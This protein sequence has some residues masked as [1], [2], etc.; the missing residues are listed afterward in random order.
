MEFNIFDRLHSDIQDYDRNFLMLARTSNTNNKTGGYRYSQR[1]TVNLIELYCSSKFETGAIDS[2]GQRKFFLNIVRFRQEVAEKQ[3]DIDVK[4]FLFVPEDGTPEINAT[5]TAK[6]FRKWSREKRF[7]KVLNELNHD[8]SKY[9]TCVAKIIGD[10]IERVPLLTFRVQQDAHSIECARYAI[11]EHENMSA[12]A[13]AEYEDW[14]VEKL[15]LKF[16]ETTNVFEWYGYV[17][18]DW[19]NEQNGTQRS[20]KTGS[21]YVQAILAPDKSA[22]NSSNKGGTILF[23]EETECL[24]REAHYSRIDG[25][26]LGVGEVEKNFENQIFRNVVS[27]MRR[28]GLIWASKKLFQSSDPD[29]GQNLIRDVKDGDVLKVAPNGEIKQINM[30]TQTVGEFDDAAKEI[31]QN[32]DQTSFTFEVA[33]GEGLPSGTPFRLGVILSKAVDSYYA[34][35]RENFGLFLEDMFYDLII[36]VFK[37]ESR[38]EHLLFFKNDEN[39]IQAIRSRIIDFYVYRNAMDEILKGKHINLDQIRS[40]VQEKINRNDGE[41]L[42]IPEGFYDMVKATVI[43]VT[44]GENMDVGKRIESLT[45][46]YQALVKSG[47]P[48]AEKVLSKIATLAGEDPS[49]FLASKADI[50][51][52]ASQIPAIPSVGGQGI[53]GGP[54]AAVPQNAPE[55]VAQPA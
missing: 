34:L 43:L 11:I 8:Y 2:E 49:D 14:D 26:W 45:N 33:T 13:M 38:K 32:A 16:G 31:D 22:K 6:A 29:I 20:S 25:R 4:D 10:C 19:F 12:E 21:I 1:D 36:P 52:P 35:K 53:P 44:T 40:Q 23:L 37:K 15:G 7:G 51:A 24:F 46:F 48:R 50:P 5:I 47:D 17:P 18:V 9:G 30:A 28:R 42:K 39:G 41:W 3:T 55:A 27:N 54:N